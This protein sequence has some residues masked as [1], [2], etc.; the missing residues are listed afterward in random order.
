MLKRIVVLILFILFFIF[1]FKILDEKEGGRKK[2]KK[3]QKELSIAKNSE[4]SGIYTRDQFQ[5]ADLLKDFT[6]LAY[7]NQK[8]NIDWFVKQ[9][10]DGGNSNIQAAIEQLQTKKSDIQQE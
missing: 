3:K 2:K 6:T 4:S 7:T 10:I 9:T 8:E 5:N 1:I